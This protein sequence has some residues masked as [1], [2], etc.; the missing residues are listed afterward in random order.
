MQIRADADEYPL[1]GQDRRDE[2]HEE[3]STIK[4]DNVSTIMVDTH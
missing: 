4:V 2:P 3:M 1:Q